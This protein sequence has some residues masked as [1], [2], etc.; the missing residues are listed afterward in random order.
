MLRLRPADL[1]QRRPPENVEILT[2]D[3]IAAAQQLV[4]VV[5]TRVEAAEEAAAQR[6]GYPFAA[7]SVSGRTGLG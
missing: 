2:L 7:T 3:F 6:I 4:E 1:S 5:P